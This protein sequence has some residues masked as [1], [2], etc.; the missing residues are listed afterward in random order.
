[1]KVGWFS[2]YSASGV[3]TAQPVVI[4][5]LRVRHARRKY[6]FVLVIVA[7][8]ALAA[9]NL[10]RSRIGRAW[11]AVRDMDV[12]AGHRHPDHADQAHRVRGQLVL[13]RRRGRALRV[14]V[15]RHVEPDGFNLDL[16]F[17][18]LFMIIIGGVGSIMG[19]FLGAA[20]IVLL[21]IISRTWC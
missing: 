5:R 1:V 19:S 17:R 20:F 7:V 8:L 15:S 14:R 4:A 13:L 12:A 2:N 18:I 16:S 6:L 11:M 10:V 3:I 21:P 9:K